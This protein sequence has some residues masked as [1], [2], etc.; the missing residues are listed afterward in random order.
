MNALASFAHACGEQTN[1]LLKTQDT[2]RADEW[3]N[4]LPIIHVGGGD[5]IALE[6][7]T[8]RD[9][10]DPPVV[11]LPRNEY[12]RPLANSFTGFL[13]EWERL[14]YLGPHIRHLDRFLYDDGLLTPGA[15]S[16]PDRLREFLGLP[17]IPS[18][19]EPPRH[20]STPRTP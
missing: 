14:C 9:A 16:T 19:Q 7:N 2:D 17:V 3:E 12:G 4:A 20:Q 15:E 10:E 1:Q 8:W 6:T 13:T 5:Y 18:S 11:Y